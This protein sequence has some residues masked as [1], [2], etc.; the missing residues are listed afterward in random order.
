M[1]I[2]NNKFAQED[3][4]I[5]AELDVKV[6]QQAA[7]NK[8]LKTDITQITKDLEQLKEAFEARRQSGMQRKIGMIEIFEGERLEL[9]DKLK[10]RNEKLAKAKREVELFGKLRTEIFNMSSKLTKSKDQ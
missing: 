2:A 5:I 1:T 8:R 7:E 4:N 6:V 3:A 10:D 9:M